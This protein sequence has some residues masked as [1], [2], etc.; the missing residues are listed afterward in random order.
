M[1]LQR[2]IVKAMMKLP[3]SWK[4]KLAGGEAVIIGGRTLDPNFQLI[5]HGAASQPALSS[6]E[7][8]IA[9][10]A[11]KQ[12]MAQFAARPEPGVNWQDITISGTDNNDIPIRIYRPDD[13]D[14]TA[15]ILAYWHM[16]GG[17]ILD[18][19]ACHAFCSILAK[20]V[21]CP[22]AS[23]D[24]R[25]AP[26]HRFPAGLEDCISAYDWALKH[27]SE[28]GAPA[29]RASIGGD[30]M[31]GNFSAIIAQETRRRGMPGPDL[32][33]LIYP[34]TDLVTRFESATLYA[35]TYPLSSDT[36]TWFMQQ[37]LPDSMTFDR[38]DV[39]VSPALETRL[40][41]LA[42]AIIVTA[43]FDPLADD[44]AAY[45][46]KL[47]AAGVPVRFKCY[48]SLAHG[49]T[50]FTDLVPDARSACLE[51]AAMVRDAY[52]GD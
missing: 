36:M 31:G 4:I 5:A 43:G 14:P 42:P 25:L 50:A 23:V 6:M 1:S 39:R 41:G 45:A 10:A 18:I 44:G 11:A 21:R 12:G 15:P 38:S 34:A 9:Q 47:K 49:F 40:D 17:V 22:V 33:L 52:A 16:G 26:Q 48:D 37:Y 46:Q 51:I 13:Q 7:P 32:Q 27:A 3:N 8:T 19:E 24:Y 20:T 35:E 29:G 2:L 28:Y 30:S